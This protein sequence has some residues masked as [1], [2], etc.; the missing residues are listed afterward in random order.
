MLNWDLFGTKKQRH[1]LVQNK[2]HLSQSLLSAWLY[3]YKSTEGYEAFIK[4]LNRQRT[5]DTE[6]I[7]DGKAFE[8]AVNQHLN[9]A[10]LNGISYPASGWVPG[11]ERTCEYLW[12]SR[13]QV[14]LRKDIIVEGCCFNLVGVLDF[15]KAGV[16]YDTKFSK[17]YYLNK[18][19]N[20]PQHSAYFYLVPEAY[21]FQ[22][23][24]CD[25][26]YVYR[27]IYRPENTK[28]IEIYIKQFMHF[29]D[30]QKL[31]DLYVQNFNLDN[32]YK[33]KK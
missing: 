28:P 20:S 4:A 25:G 16:I 26:T 17:N 7:L 6:A 1:G 29:L 31:T 30:Q 2:F 15:L 11:I 27:E 10:P 13:Q 9:G 3:S 22:Y 8:N 32:Y 12:D 14:S 33:E 19:L 21:E 24:S 18:Y 5:P 23:L